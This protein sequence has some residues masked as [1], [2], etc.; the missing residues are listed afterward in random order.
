MTALHE[1]P[2]TRPTYIEIGDVPR[3]HPVAIIRTPDW[4]VIRIHPGAHT[5]TVL[6]EA[7]PHLHHHEGTA[8]L[9]GFTLDHH[10]S[11]VTRFLHAPLRCLPKAYLRMPCLPHVVPDILRPPWWGIN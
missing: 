9:R 3:N 8:W 7:A 5:P 6:E 10:P 1:H 2:I 11:A 4:T